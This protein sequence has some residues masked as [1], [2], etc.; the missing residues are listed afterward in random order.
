VRTRAW[1]V[2]HTDQFIVVTNKAT[3]RDNRNTLPESA[4]EKSDWL[5]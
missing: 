5:L 2:D 4:A 1:L 3:K